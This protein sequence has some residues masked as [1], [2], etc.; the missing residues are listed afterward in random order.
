MA[1][2]DD[3]HLTKE[4]KTLFLTLCGKA[5]DYRSKNSVLNDHTANDI[6]EKSGFDL[7]QYSGSK[8]RIVAVRA[9][10]FDEWTTNF[11]TQNANAVVV[12]MGCGLDTRISRIKP[13]A[14]ILWFDVDFPEVIALRKRFYADSENYKMIPNSVTDEGWLKNIPNDR[15]AII[16]AEG[17][18]SYLSKEE[19]RILLNRLTDY[20]P[21]GEII[22]NVISGLAKQKGIKSFG[23]I[24]KM[25]VE[26]VEEVDQLDLKMKRIETL[27]LFESEFI[28]GL[29]FMYRTFLGLAAGSKKYKNMIRLLRYEF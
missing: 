17:L 26:D 9:R 4:Q 24:Q 12:N 7:E 18:M 6:I 1:T 27:S 5:L 19:V 11:I 15:P 8:N 3:L 21:N 2:I 20:F 10:Q 16:I 13:N 29:P 14:G 28:K 22:F 25:T 23:A